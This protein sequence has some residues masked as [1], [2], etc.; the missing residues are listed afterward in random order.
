MEDGLP[1]YGNFNG[2]NHVPNFQTIK[3][4]GPQFQTNPHLP[5]AVGSQDCS[6]SR[7][8]K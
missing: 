2:E 3:F 4:E 7:R 1:M 8:S 5:W 6:R